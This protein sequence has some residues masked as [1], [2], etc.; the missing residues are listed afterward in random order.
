MKKYTYI[1]IFNEFENNGCLLLE[2]KYINSKTKMKYKCNCGNISEIIWNDFQQGRRCYNCRNKKITEKRKLS[3][4]YVYNYFKDQGCELLEK[5]YKNSHTK[6]EYKCDCGNISKI[7]FKDFK[8]GNRCK[9][10]YLENNK[11]SNSGR[12]NPNKKELEIN[13]KI[14]IR[15]SKK[16][17]IKNMKDDP[18]Y[19]NY[20]NNYNNYQLDHILP[21]SLFVKLITTYNLNENQIKKIVNK[22]ENLQILTIQEN[23]KK[24]DKGD[25]FQ[26]VQFLINNGIDILKFEID[27]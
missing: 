1:E 26:A 21:I 4:K 3:Y 23:S 10:C 5:E 16:W 27:Q 9:Q 6:M 22:K 11:G 20:L 17:I 24:S 2:P 15:K 13:L 25:I 7:R 8:R 18:N 14:R 19:Y 12:W